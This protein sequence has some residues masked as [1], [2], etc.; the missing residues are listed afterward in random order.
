MPKDVFVE[1]LPK[2]IAIIMDGNGRWAREKTLP[3]TAGHRK[4]A[5]RVKEIISEARVLGIKALTIFA[6]S[7]ENWDRP[8]K[9]IVFLFNYLSKFLASYRNKLIKE[10]INFKVIGR[11]DRISRE[12][13]RQIEELEEVTSKNGELYLKVAIDYGGRWDIVNASRNIVKECRRG[14]MKPSD[15]DEDCFQ[16]YLSVGEF[17]EVDLFIRTSGEK[18]ISNFLIW[19]LA[20]TELVF[21]NVYWPDFT[22]DEFRKSIREYSRRNRR[23]GRINA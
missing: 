7:T 9:E 23:F 1:N 21:S 14:R 18:R 12:I 8:K 22:R 10:K 2:H 15:I 13:L 20:Y 6:F 17:P 11:R 19:N 3:R 5:Q 16:K 4:G